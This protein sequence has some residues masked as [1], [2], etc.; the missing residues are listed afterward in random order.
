[1]YKNVFSLFLF[2]AFFSSVYSQGNK[3]DLINKQCEEINKNIEENYGY[4]LT[5]SLLLQSNLRA[6]GIQNT[7]IK[8]FYT[9]P[10]DSIVE[11][12]GETE[13]INIYKPPL[14]IKVQYNIAASQDVTVEYYL[15]KDGNLIYYTYL[16]TGLYTNGKEQYYF[17]KNIPVKI[18]TEA[19]DGE[20]EVLEKYLFYEKESD[21]TES[22]LENANKIIGKKNSYF[23][24][25]SK[26]PAIEKIDK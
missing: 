10:E 13:F 25:F 19:I 17:E 3:V 15:D 24:L 1:M 23:D 8:F 22:D 20:T 2:L 4:Y 6:I 14:K 16:T 9:Q 7:S 18:K 5:Y 26:I 12:N 21:F 11:K